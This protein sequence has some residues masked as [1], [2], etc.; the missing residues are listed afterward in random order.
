MRALSGPSRI[1]LALA[2][3]AWALGTS[4]PAF[5]STGAA[6]D[7]ALHAWR[8]A[9]RAEVRAGS[10]AAAGVDAASPDGTG[11]KTLRGAPVAP[12]RFGLLV[13]PVDFADERLPT[14]WDP[15]SLAPRLTA[16]GG[17]SLAH[18]FQVASA[19]RCEVVPVLAPLVHLAGA[20]LDYSDVGRNGFTRTR[21]LA[22]E[23]LA[24]VAAGGYDF[25]LADLDGPDRTAGTADDDGW[26][27]GVLILHAEAGQENDADEGVVQALQY[28]LE[29]PVV[30]DGVS[31]G[32]YAVASLHSGPGIW[33]HETAHLLG[34]EDRYDPLLPPD[35]GA[36][37][38][39]GAGG[40]GVFSLMAAGA[41]GTGGGWNPSLPD[42]YSRALLGWCDVVPLEAS[43]AAGDTLIA[44]PAGDA[45]RSLWTGGESG[46]EFF[47]LEARD[48]ALAAPFDAA[49]PAAGL[50]ALHVD[51]R[52]PEGSWF[53]DGVGSW[54]LRARVVE[55]DGDRDLEA[56]RDTGSGGDV[57]PGANGVTAWTPASN[58]STA[59]YGGPSGVA[60]TGIAPLAA[61]VVL[62]G[63]AA[64]APWL[65]ADLS[66]T[67]GAAP[68]L[69]LAVGLHGGAATQLTAEIQAVG[70][71]RWGAFTNGS[72]SVTVELQPT[73]GGV[74]SP[75]VP[76]PWTPEPGLPDG[77]CTR[78][79]VAVSGPGLPTLEA[80]REWCWTAQAGV[81][82]FA[83]AW[84][85][86][87]THDTPGGPGTSWRRW[88]AAETD[89]GGGRPLLVCAADAAQPGDWPHI[90]YANGRRARLT[91]GPLAIGTPAVR[92][93]HWVDLE[94]LPGGVPMDGATASWVGPDGAEVPAE[95]WRG[96]PARVDATSG[97]DLRSRGSFGAEPGEL[98]ADGRPVWRTD[99]L[100]LPASGPGPWRLRLDLAANDLWRGRGWLIGGCEAVGAPGDLDEGLR[101]GDELAWHWR[102]PLGGSFT[103]QA[104]ALPDSAW[105][106]LVTT[107]GEAVAG[108]VLRARLAGVAGVRRELRVTGPCPWGILAL[109]PV[110]V[111]LDGGATAPAALGE[112][113]PNPAPGSVRFTLGV[114]AGGAARLCVYDLRGRLVHE[115]AVGP[116]V[117][118]GE[119]DGN[120]DRGRRLPSG[121][122]FLRLVGAGAPATRKVVLQ[123]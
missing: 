59:G 83:A 61:G 79:Q 122:Y 118:F 78:F 86:A 66:F 51:E 72:G 16:A 102:W 70:P 77:A 9:R 121:T 71:E 55:A 97:C 46:D 14:G 104:R 50:V 63:A 32:P 2:T 73:A 106:T 3:L 48:P 15:A 94:L 113:W 67:A 103:V 105:T 8:A 96:W 111:Y 7:G 30:S 33:A 119:W 116:G 11:D 57:F 81:L 112:P 69:Q 31:A 92:L 39:A 114:P 80:S 74:W 56:G 53:E 117:L 108:G 95:P 54:H 47:L 21:R 98:G 60:V 45:V 4:T 123:H 75:V 58:P 90:S 18:Y 43:P 52:V 107:T 99:I 115:R 82:D 12:A 20:A 40:L 62:H 34:M 24:A 1:L 101:W 84:P 44:A 64:A 10:L 13:V 100:P 42:A 41:R 27:D 26:V 65:T 76:V 37:D 22:A 29:E 88:T 87:W 23:A 68:D 17:Q 85:G 28:Y 5:A 89:L 120:D 38:L 36:G 49:L 6:G 110:A 35:A 25:R 93:V 19:G 91:S 109:A